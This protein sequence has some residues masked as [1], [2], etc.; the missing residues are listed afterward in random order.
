MNAPRRNWIPTNSASC[1]I[2]TT[3]AFVSGPRTVTRVSLRCL[4]TTSSQC[5]SATE[6]NNSTGTLL[7]RQTFSTKGEL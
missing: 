2:A 5:G 7:A 6:M 1:G 3:D 4:V